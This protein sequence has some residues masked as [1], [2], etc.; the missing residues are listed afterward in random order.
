MGDSANHLTPDD[1]ER[2]LDA[3][4]QLNAKTSDESIRFLF[5]IMYWCGLRVSEALQ[6]TP[7]HVH[8]DDGILALGKT[9]TGTGQIV[10]LPP[11]MI[12]LAKEYKAR[13]APGHPRLREPVVT[14]SRMTVWR[15]IYRLGEITGIPAL[16]STRD[17]TNEDLGTHI[18]RKAIAH[19]MLDGGAP[20]NVIGKH[21]RHKSLASTTKYLQIDNDMVREWFE[22]DES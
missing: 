4:P 6:V 2:M 7:N 17:E 5:N 14:V 20:L 22:R 18:F 3:I 13:W 12:R 1:R 19:D 15:W 9:K 21:L 16:L 8:V 10:V 11:E